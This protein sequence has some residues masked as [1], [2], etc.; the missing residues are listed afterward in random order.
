[1][2]LKCKFASDFCYCAHCANNTHFN[3]TQIAN[4]DTEAFNNSI[5]LASID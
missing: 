4:I 2:T 3:S 1:M 5:S